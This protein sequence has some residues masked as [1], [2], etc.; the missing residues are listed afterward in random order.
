MRLAYLLSLVAAGVCVF[1]KAIPGTGTNDLANRGMNVQRQI[2]SRQMKTEMVR[3]RQRA[4]AASKRRNAKAGS[5]GLFGRLVA[6]Q[7]PA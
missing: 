1:S 6:E 3:L 2:Q 5:G 4:I 7:C